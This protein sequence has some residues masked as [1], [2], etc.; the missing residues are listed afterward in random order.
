M[1]LANVAESV[2][3]LSSRARVPPAWAGGS[4]GEPGAA[5]KG[6]VL[7]GETTIVSATAPIVATGPKSTPVDERLSEPPIVKRPVVPFENSAEW[8]ELAG[9]PAESAFSYARIVQAATDRIPLLSMMN[10]SE[11]WLRGHDGTRPEPIST[12]FPE[13]RAK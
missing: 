3:D 5:A 13:A 4:V 2:S 1:R 7:D 12:G 6:P 10:E 11:C 9:L 8:E